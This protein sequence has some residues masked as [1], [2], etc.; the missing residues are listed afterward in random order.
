MEAMKDMIGTADNA[1]VVTD[2]KKHPRIMDLEEFLTKCLSG[3]RTY[4][5]EVRFCQSNLPSWCVHQA[6]C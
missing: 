2:N 6:S 4:F 5:N 3:F 1:N